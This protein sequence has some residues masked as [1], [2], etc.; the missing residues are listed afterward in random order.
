MI[1]QKFKEVSIVCDVYESV[2]TTVHVLGFRGQI[3]GVRSSIVSPSVVWLVQQ[4]LYPLH[5]CIRILS[6]SMCLFNF[7]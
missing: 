1:I 5:H 7:L 4:A 6:G 2:L 3:S